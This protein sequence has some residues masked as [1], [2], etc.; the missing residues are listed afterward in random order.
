MSRK[1]QSNSNWKS[2]P[3]GNAR[4]SEATDR[5]RFVWTE[6][7]YSAIGEQVARIAS[8]FP[9]N[10]IPLKHPVVSELLE[11]IRN[12]E[13]CVPHFHPS[14]LENTGR[15]SHGNTT[16][17]IFFYIYVYISPSRLN[18]CFIFRIQ[19]VHEDPEGR[20]ETSTAGHRCE[21]GGLGLGN[22]C[23]GIL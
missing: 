1:Q 12:S 22:F 10:I 13:S 5:R 17:N 3:W 4:S 15:L 11:A 16:I 7:E 9:G 8:R 19:A 14:H 23:I 20:M 2:K 18:D 6:E 21:V